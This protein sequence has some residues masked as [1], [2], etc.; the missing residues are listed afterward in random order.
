MPVPAPEA[1]A[2]SKTDVRRLLESKKVN[3]SFRATS[4]RDAVCKLL[5]TAGVN[6]V[7]DGHVVADGSHPVTLEVKERVGKVL[8][9]ILPESAGYVVRNGTVV[10]DT[11][12]RLIEQEPLELRVYDV[13]D[14]V[15]VGLK[16]V[17]Q[18]D[19][20]KASRLID[21][22]LEKT[23]AKRWREVTLIGLNGAAVA[24]RKFTGRAS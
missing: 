14:V 15:H 5:E 1:E 19:R 4:L 7:L 16:D 21:M 18:T 9:R 2:V 10:I 23:G 12:E 22:I 17:G 3:L 20:D 8:T 13:R 6:F 11:K 24:K